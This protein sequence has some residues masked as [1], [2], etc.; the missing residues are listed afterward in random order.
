MVGSAPIFLD[1]RR[2]LL[3]QELV[4]ARSSQKAASAREATLRMELAPLP[5]DHERARAI[6]SLILDAVGESERCRDEEIRIAKALAHLRDKH[7]KSPSAAAEGTVVLQRPHPIFEGPSDRFFAAAAAIVFTGFS[8]LASIILLTSRPAPEAHH[9]FTAPPPARTITVPGPVERVPVNVIP[10]GYVSLP[11]PPQGS[12][13][14][15]VNGPAGTKVFEK[16]RLL[17]TVPLVMPL[18]R[19]THT[20]HY[21]GVEDGERW[22]EDET[23]EITPGAPIRAGYPDNTELARMTAQNPKLL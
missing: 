9:A 7:G 22:A 13:W 4:I 2:R 6:A 20:L 15:I 16:K 5:P 8:L 21:D 1:R 23:V 17:G 10:P 12:G 11:Q 14:L 3:E 19:G 18:P